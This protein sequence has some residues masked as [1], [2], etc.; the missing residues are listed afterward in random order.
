M[1]RVISLRRRPRVTYGTSSRLCFICLHFSSME[2]R[3]GHPGG[4]YFSSSP[5][6][7]LSVCF[8]VL[9]VCCGALSSMIRIFGN[10]RDALFR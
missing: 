10:R 4:R 3:S 1:S 7:S 6:S 5:S 8:T 2:L 9:A